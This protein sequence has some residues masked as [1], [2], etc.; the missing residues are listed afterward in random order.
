MFE[1][2]DIETLIRLRAFLLVLAVMI[3]WEFVAP[4]RSGSSRLRRWPANFG[5]LL[6][7]A[8]MLG[9]LPVTAVAASLL[10]LELKFGLFIWLKLSLWPSIILSLLILDVVIYW[11]HRI[12]HMITPLWRVHRMHHTD[13]AFDVS[14]ALRFHPVEILISILL[15]AVVIVLLGAPILAVI[16]F[17]IILNASAM[18]NHSNIRMPLLV[19]KIVRYI[20]VTPDMHRV[21]HSVYKDERDFNF[22]FC[23]SV[24]DR[25]FGSYVD[26]PKDGH[27]GMTIGLDV[28]SGKD[29]ARLD[30]LL[31]QPFRN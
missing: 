13:T 10:S 25:L 1:S 14:T 3:I 2:L 27:Q 9:A 23:L 28:F 15:K 31:T 12:F 11:Q 24:W 6:L 4:R 18:F 5:I 22:G 19:D 30:K 8:L 29:E 20:I 26:Q 16:A 17:E 21:H 7:N